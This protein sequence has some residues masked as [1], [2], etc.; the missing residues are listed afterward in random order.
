MK[1]VKDLPGI[2]LSVKVLTL[3]LKPVQTELKSLINN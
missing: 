2:G 3:R 1:T